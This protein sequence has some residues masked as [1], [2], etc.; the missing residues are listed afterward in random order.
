MRRCE[1][2][3]EE[4]QGGRKGRNVKGVF[5]ARNSILLSLGPSWLDLIATV[6]YELL[7]G[8]LVDFVSHAFIAGHNARITISYQEAKS[9]HDTDSE[10]RHVPIPCTVLKLKA[11]G[12]DGLSYP[13]PH[14]ASYYTVQWLV[15]QTQES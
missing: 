13:F 8:L 6:L 2:V 14:P 11:L 4:H 3:L 1:E 15:D 7:T 10:C 12:G 9:H 5:H